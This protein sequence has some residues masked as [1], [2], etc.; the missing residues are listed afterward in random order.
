MMTAQAESR[1][2]HRFQ[3]NLPI[4]VRWTGG[5]QSG[6]AAG[7]IRDINEKGVYFITDAELPADAAIEFILERP[8]ELTTDSVRR[9]LFSGKIVRVERA[10]GSQHGVAA[11]LEQC[12][13]LSEGQAEEVAAKISG[14]WREQI[15]AYIKDEQ[16]KQ[17][18]I[19]KQY[20]SKTGLASQIAAIVLGIVLALAVANWFFSK[21]P[22]TLQ[23]QLTAGNPNAQVWVHTKSGLYYCK[24]DK[25]YANLHPG[26]YMN[27]REAQLNYNRPATGR[28]CQ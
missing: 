20:R 25:D 26:R 3:L 13:Q 11:Q 12:Q 5:E 9:L 22:D 18:E 21:P 28:P 19:K 4:K 6:T 2:L 16:E 14:D 10:N 7:T 17:K 23:R 8:A 15:E 27:Q 1:R 24:E